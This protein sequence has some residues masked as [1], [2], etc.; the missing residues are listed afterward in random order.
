M[1][2]KVI[3]ALIYTIVSVPLLYVL[4]LLVRMLM[5]D[6]FTVPSSSM[7]PT[8]MPGSKVI[9][10]K[11]IFGPRIYTNLHFNLNGQELES[12]RLKGIRGIRHNDIVV[13]NY[14]IHNDRI[15]F[16]INNVF[17]KRVTGLREIQ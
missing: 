14:P 7:T 16:V 15:S 17:C 8:I 13:F 2:R 6:Y 3:K 4:W 5:F 9:V 12:I 11:M 1:M 10:N